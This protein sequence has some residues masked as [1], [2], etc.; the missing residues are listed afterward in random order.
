[1][2]IS[3]PGIYDIE[4]HE[5]HADPC[6]PFS[7]SATG[8]KSIWNE[9]Q[10]KCVP[11]KFHHWRT[12]PQESKPEWDFGRLAH[13][14]V[15]GKG[16]KFEVLD[17]D[18]W[19]TKAAREAALASREA[20]VVPVLRKTYRKACDMRDALK[21]S[22]MGARAFRGGE[23]E[24]TLIWR[25]PETG[26]W[27]RAMA[28]CFI[29]AN[30]M[31]VDYKTTESADPVKIRKSIFNFG[32]HIQ[33]AHYIN[34]AIELGLLKRDLSRPLDTWPHFIFV[35]QEKNPPHLTTIIKLQNSALECG[36]LLVRKAIN[37]IADCAKKD[38]WPG[39]ADDHVLDV[40]LPEWAEMRI[41][42]AEQKGAY[43]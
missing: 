11:A 41:D 29:T 15:L 8:I 14:L 43:E 23:I 7:V 39:Y 16:D 25:D 31:F 33:A 42:D 21:S 40:G 34:G 13:Q 12:T 3:E 37:V 36:Q 2:I 38:K 35:F 4:A 26:L 30:N 27:C 20:G 32:Y 24:K 6:E 18:D 1:M 22:K 5:Y 17:F 28:D 10:D 19:R 9:D